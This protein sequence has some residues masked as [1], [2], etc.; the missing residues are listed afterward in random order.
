[1]DPYLE[2]GED[3]D[4][5]GEDFAFGDDP[6]SDLAVRQQHGPIRSRLHSRGHKTQK[7]AKVLRSTKRTKKEVDSRTTQ[8][9]RASALPDD[10][11]CGFYPDANFDYVKRDVK[12]F[13]DNPE[14]SLG[15]GGSGDTRYQLPLRWRCS[16]S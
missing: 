4:E 7:G 3:F 15:G 8:T 11:V 16:W 1:M 2:D 14:N 13:A 12:S 10:F 9:G 6:S 5:H